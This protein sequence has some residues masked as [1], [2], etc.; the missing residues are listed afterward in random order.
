MPSFEV[1]RVAAVQ[2]TP[3]ILDLEATIDKAV[4]LLDEASDAGA[5]LVVLGE[6]FVSLYPTGAWAAQAATWADGCNELWERFWASSVDVRGPHVPAT[7][8][9]VRSS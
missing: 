5:Q 3:V 4:S 7:R 9:R 2:A 8:R 6:C 1:L